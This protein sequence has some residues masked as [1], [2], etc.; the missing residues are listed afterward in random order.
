[1]SEK[2]IVIDNGS[3][4]IKAGFSGDNQPSVK[5]PSIVGVPR[6][7][8][9]MVGV[10]SKSEYIGDEAQKMRGVLKLSYPIESGIVTDW[11]Q[12]EKVWEYCFSNELRC[13]PSE[14]KVMLTEAPSNPKANREKMTQ[15]MFETFQ[16]QGLYVAIQAVLSLYSNGRT[17]GMVCDSGDGVTHT[18]PVYEG[19]SIPHAVKKNYIAG[20]AI[21]DHMAK[22][23]QADGITEQGGQSAWRQIIRKIKE[24]L[25]FVSLDP[26][27]DK[28]KA[29]ESTELQKNYELPDGQTV[30]INAPRFM[31]PEALFF[32][33]LIKEGDEVEGMHKM[34]FSSIQECDIDI[35]KDLYSNVILS[36][37]TTL[38]AGLPDRLEK[39]LDAMCPQQNMV[40]IIASGD[41]YYSVWTGGST[42]SSLS[43]FESQWIT[44]DEYEENGAEIVHRKCV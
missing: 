15:L 27:A 14:H 37:G 30:P 28:T 13:D 40:K 39:E 42:L 35:R 3:G 43:T 17:T 8:K 16:V 22:L 2:S 24:D 12:M 34:T 23:L 6:T 44:K 5:F 4:V 11:G 33:D 19:F 29:A 20:R 26:A 41:R 9:Q 18:V 36:G 32:P 38:Y 25:C 21:T 7:D 10:E 1:M 31:A